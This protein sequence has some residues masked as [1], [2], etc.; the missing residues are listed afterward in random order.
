MDKIRRNSPKKLL[1]LVSEFDKFAGSKIKIQNLLVFLHM[2][3]K[4]S[5]IEI[6][7]ANYNGIKNMK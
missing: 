5:K 2:N 4:Q 3:N 1:E 6:N 7:N